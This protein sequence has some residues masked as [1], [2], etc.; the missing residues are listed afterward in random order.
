MR[1]LRLLWLYFRLGALNELAYRA[2]FFVQLIQSGARVFTTLSALAVVFQY[3]DTLAGWRPAELV[4]LTGIYYMIGGFV[5][6]VI[7]PSMTKLMESVRLGTLDFVLTKPEDAQLLVSVQQVQVWMLV[8]VCIGLGI[9]ITGLVWLGAGVGVLQALAF[10][11]TLLAGSAVVYSVLLSLAT[12]SF[13]LVRLENVL[14]IFN[15][16]YDA[17]RYP[18][19]IY[20]PWLRFALTYLVPVAFAVTV[21]AE[22]VVGRLSWAHLGSAVLVAGAALAFSRWFW[23]LGVRHYS[24]A[25]A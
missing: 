20:P 24:G 14:V 1:A 4:A 3:T 22:A 5:G 9:L 7:R 10:G 15:S 8:D 11:L 18:V 12:L 13:W 2:N 21:P 23:R 16:L 19:S 25:S 6:L 17:G